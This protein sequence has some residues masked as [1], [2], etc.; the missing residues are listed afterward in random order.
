MYNYIKGKIIDNEENLLVV[1]AGGIG[2]ELTVSSYAAA[3]LSQKEGDV[4]VYCYLSVREDDM[5]L[6]GFVS[7]REKAMFERLIGISGVGPKLAITVLSGLSVEQ[8]ASVI[9]RGDVKTLSTVKG[10]G[11]KTAERIVLELKDKVNSD[12]NAADGVV[13]SSVIGAPKAINEEAV[14]A[15]MTLG[16][17]RVES[18]AAVSRVNVDG[19][20]LEQIIF[21]ALR[22]A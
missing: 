15:L 4:K 6:F 7:K 17:T 21:N 1:E 20:T 5:S 22:N 10:V 11:K 18:E 2:Y 12:Y 14:L 8:L 16:Y 13:T 19:L 9:A 3:E